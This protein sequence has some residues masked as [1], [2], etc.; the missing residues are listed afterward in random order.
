MVYDSS[1]FSWVVFALA[2]VTTLFLQI[3]SNL[4]NDYGDFVKGTDN[5]SRVGP[6][7][8]LQSGIISKREMQVGI[9][10]FVLGSLL[11]GIQLLWIAFENRWASF[12]LFFGLGIV[13]ILAALFYTIGKKPYGYRAMGDIFVFVFFG[14]V[15][16]LGS[17]FLQTSTLEYFHLLPAIS[18]GLFAVGVLN[19]NNIRDLHADKAARKITIPVLLGFEKAKRYHLAIL[20]VGITSIT[21]FGVWRFGADWKL[22][23]LAPLLM[24]VNHLKYVWKQTQNQ[25]LDS[26]L[27]KV[28][29]AA[30][31]TS[32]I[33]SIFSWIQFS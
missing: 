12:W 27:K 23:F 29:L 2:L 7:R 16:V 22:L 11:S 1:S 9:A 5:E 10:V 33:F 18:Q 30:F 15:G 13:A 21:I 32:I 24:L 20:A 26:E 17:A 28:A 31:L 25:A 6:A 19:M 8:S 14:L 3:L 4:A